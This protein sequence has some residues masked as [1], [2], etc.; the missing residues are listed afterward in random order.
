M[1][2]APPLP[3]RGILPVFD[4]LRRYSPSFLWLF[5]C[6]A[7]RLEVQAGGGNGT[8]PVGT[9]P[10]SGMAS[11][12][13]ETSAALS[14]APA[15]LL[16]IPTT[17]TLSIPMAE[18]V[19]TPVG[20]IPVKQMKE[21]QAQSLM[22]VKQISGAD[23]EAVIEFTMDPPDVAKLPNR[24]TFNFWL[25][26][27]KES[28]PKVEMVSAEWIVR[29]MDNSTSGTFELEKGGDWGPLPL[30]QRAAQPVY[31]DDFRGVGLFRVELLPIAPISIMST[32]GRLDTAIL[33]KASFKVVQPGKASTMTDFATKDPFAVQIISKMAANPQQ[34]QYVAEAPA[35]PANE[36]DI[37]AWS[38]LMRD[39]EQRGGLLL[40]RLPRGGL[41]RLTGSDLTRAGLKVEDVPV[42]ALRIF[43]G[44]N[45]LR[46]LP[47]AIRDDRMMFSG[48][49]L[50]FYVPEDLTDRK[51]FLPLWIMIG[52]PNDKPLRSEFKR[53]EVAFAGDG[54][55]E[56]SVRVRI[57][58]PNVYDHALPVTGPQLKWATEQIRYNAIGEYEFESPAV[59]PDSQATLDIWLTGMNPSGSANYGLYIN[60][61]EIKSGTLRGLT[62][63]KI[64]TSFGAE[65]LRKGTNKL[66]VQNREVPA[67]MP[68]GGGT[69]ISFLLADF[70]LP[71]TTRDALPNQQLTLTGDHPTTESLI[72]KLEAPAEGSGVVADVTDSLSPEFF[73]IIRATTG[74]DTVFRSNAQ[75]KEGK[76]V[77]LYASDEMI[78]PLPPLTRTSVPQWFEHPG[79]TDYLAI[80]HGPL[81]GELA[82]LLEYRKSQGL[83]V[84]QMSVDDVYNAFSYGEEKY[85]AIYDAIQWVYTEFPG[86]RVREVLLVGEG[87]EYWWEYR[88]PTK[89]VT[90]NMLPVFGW[91]DS[92]IQIRGDDSYTL[93]SGNGPMSDVELGRISVNTPEELKIMVKKI[94]GYEQSAPSGEWRNRNLFVTDD[95]PEFEQVATEIVEKSM[96]GANLPK[97]MLLQDFPYE[98]Y[99]RG[100]WRKRSSQMTDRLVDV[101]NQ[102][103]LTVTYI[104]HGGPNLWSSERILHIR[105]VDRLEDGGRHAIL[106]AGSCDT[107]WVDYPVDPVRSS[108]S[109]QLTRKENG[110][111]VAAF[112]PIDGTSS[113]EHNYLLTAFFQAMYKDGYRDV[114]TA[115][116][117]AKLNYH[118]YRNNGR[119]TNQYLLMGDPA[120][121]LPEEGNT[122]PVSLE[123]S[124]V[125]TDNAGSL[126]YTASFEPL[127][128]GMADIS[129]MSP[130]FKEIARQRQRVMDG[131]ISGTIKIPQKLMEGE[132]HLVILASNDSKDIHAS[133]T[134]I[135]RVE[136]HRISALCEPG[137]PPDK[138]LETGQ[139]VEIAYG[140]KNDS[141]LPLKRATVRLWNKSKGAETVREII[142]L[143]PGETFRR[144]VTT[145]MAKGANAF[146]T[147]VFLNDP[148]PDATG[149]PVARE[150][151]L[152]L[153]RD[154]EMHYLDF[155]PAAVRVASIPNK[156]GTRIL[157]PLYNMQEQATR[158]LAVRLKWMN[159]PEG[160]EIGSL[161]RLPDFAPQEGRTVVFQTDE[162]IPG[163]T[164]DFVLETYDVSH[165]GPRMVETTRAELGLD[166]GP[167]IEI[168]KDSLFLENEKPLAGSTLF[169]HFVVKNVGR[170]KATQ[171]RPQ[172]YIDQAYEDANVAVDSVPWSNP[173]EAA[174][175]APGEQK[176]FRMR[177]DPSGLTFRGTHRVFATVACSTP[178]RRLDNN[179][180]YLDVDL[181]LPPNLRLDTKNLRI[182]QQ[183]V[184]P[185]DHV[186]VTAPVMNDSSY[187]FLRDFKIGVTSI[188]NDGTRTKL[189]SQR[190]DA[191]PAGNSV[192]LQ[193]DWVVQPGENQIE[194]NLNEDREYIESD[195]S[196]NV[197]TQNFDYVMTSREFEKPKD[198]WTQKEALKFATFE[199]VQQDPNGEIGLVRR[200]GAITQVLPFKKEYLIQG[201]SGNALATDSMVGFRDDGMVISD[202]ELVSPVK[203]RFPLDPKSGT[204]Y[205]DIYLSFASRIPHGM[206]MGIFRYR[207]EDESDWRREDR[208]RGTD[209]YLGRMDVRDSALTF[210]FASAET[211]A[212]NHLMAIRAVPVMGY[213]ESPVVRASSVG[214]GVMTVD[215]ETPGDSRVEIRV[216]YGSGTNEAIAWGDWETVGNGSRLAPP[217]GTQYFQWRSMLFAAEDGSPALKDVQFNFPT[218]GS[219]AAAG[220]GGN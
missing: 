59:R 50:L 82:P 142:D 171:V 116:L 181:R 20:P 121:Q 155:M 162:T 60:G 151:A 159:K 182:S 168:V 16:D 172:L 73:P 69:A 41:F 178:E 40:T 38:A 217:T 157:I 21:Y 109:E 147:Q 105:D 117:L 125:L 111:A 193:F 165:G 102:G 213:V 32:T 209:G 149:E 135:L 203:L 128:W 174:Q 63:E 138:P 169:L 144:S 134:A 19:P 30:P 55:P 5:L 49:S 214:A 118:L 215:A 143:A 129:L 66:T 194:I 93:L 145:R 216:R 9:V 218:S 84:S 52:G 29:A 154:K 68:G 108:L 104:G 114:G 133:G 56:A 100:F 132:N 173:Q 185:Y 127:K 146:E 43:C 39:S 53:P 131:K 204:N 47:L 48:S 161:R 197:L 101:W 26:G 76:R 95:E 14:I 183:V 99:F 113:Y 150:E 190:F 31:S 152:L 198:E 202:Q 103:A 106:L 34:I 22:S 107:G 42:S 122:F 112:I 163:A 72:F 176:E 205:Y 160:T 87:S 92:D 126:D 137:A 78:R 91:N 64:S 74:A 62:T 57:F 94:M 8:P 220:P 67:D 51:S 4:L 177:W 33:R 96:G 191:L 18:V 196:D 170:E 219:V 184:Q 61:Q 12:D 28:P 201:L 70:T 13:A 192:T 115:S 211:Q 90:E 189:F 187:D 25:V 86:R 83:Y 27:Q 123:P 166:G 3:R 1:H 44:K 58:E 199:S 45:E 85:Q 54:A 179:F 158:D 175:L 11:S 208:P 36:K 79:P 65:L 136:P 98:D 141:S 195:F 77:L 7:I 15:Q 210:E 23:A 37:L 35:M 124:A 2:M 71:I 46:A 153:A 81:R 6:L 186:H 119:V 97:F 180:A 110:G 140:L 156:A 206:V 10:V 75:L 148:G 212:L 207:L 88:R 120:T 17:A 139:Q 200:P 164:Q 89:D 188:R 24:A 80:V 167:D 130:T